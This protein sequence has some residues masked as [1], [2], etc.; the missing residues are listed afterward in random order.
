MQKNLSV[1]SLAFVVFLTT[2]FTLHSTDIYHSSEG[3]IKI[4]ANLNSF[5]I[6]GD[7][8]LGSTVLVIS[9]PTKQE[10]IYIVSSCNHTESLLYKKAIGEDKMLS[11]TKLSFPTPCED[12]TIRIGDNQNIFT[13]TAVSLPIE[14]A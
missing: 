11:I 9:A 4:N 7:A 13:D 8:K 5:I 14:P 6:P 3:T 12:T 10:G 2:P 1:K